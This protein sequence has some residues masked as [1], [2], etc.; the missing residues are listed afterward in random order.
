MAE[1]DRKTECTCDLPT[2]PT[3]QSM[4]AWDAWREDCPVHGEAVR[5]G[6]STIHRDPRD[7]GAARFSEPKPCA[8]RFEPGRWCTRPDGHS[9]DCSGPER[10]DHPLATNIHPKGRIR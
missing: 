10:R 9:G 6:R 2:L 1:L 5:L 4:Y 7:D 8:H 3:P